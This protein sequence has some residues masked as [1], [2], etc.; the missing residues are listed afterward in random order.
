MIDIVKQSL[1][2][3]KLSSMHMFR[4]ADK[5][6]EGSTSLITLKNVIQSMLPDVKQEVL[7]NFLKII[8][9]NRNGFIERDEY[10]VIMMESA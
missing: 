2:K 1:A 8:D 5:D 4:L 10:A 6:D 9:S 7:F 3:R